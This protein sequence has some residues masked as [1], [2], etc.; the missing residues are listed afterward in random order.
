MQMGSVK[1][2]VIKTQCD[3]YSV[4][5]WWLDC[6][7][8]LLKNILIYLELVTAGLFRAKRR[9][10]SNRFLWLLIVSD[11]S[12]T[13]PSPTPSLRRDLFLEK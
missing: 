7:T 1:N 13:C 8:G 4:L 5:G 12:S 11:S 9:E 6:W 10:K 2:E 3:Y